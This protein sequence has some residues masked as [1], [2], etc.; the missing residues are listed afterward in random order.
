MPWAY[1][2]LGQDRWYRGDD[3]SLDATGSKSLP[4]ERVVVR[5]PNQGSPSSLQWLLRWLCGS[6]KVGNQLRFENWRRAGN[7]VVKNG[8]GYSDNGDCGIERGGAGQWNKRPT[9]WLQAIQL[10]W[11]ILWMNLSLSIQLLRWICVT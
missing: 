4:S 9:R 5:G 6:A 10:K 3:I 11:D 7:H 1:Q 2:T 8:Y